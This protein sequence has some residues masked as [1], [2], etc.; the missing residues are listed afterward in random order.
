MKCPECGTKITT[1][2]YDPDFQWYECPKCEGCFTAD[3]IEEDN[4]GTSPAKRARQNRRLG[5][6]S[7]TGSRGVKSER[8]SS[9]HSGNRSG[10]NRPVA[11]GKKRRTEI[12]EDEEA[13]ARHEAEMLK[14]VASAE[15]ETKK[16]RD[17]VSTREVVNIMADEIQAYYEELGGKIDEINAQDKALTIWR[18]VKIDTGISARE[19]DVVYATCKEHSS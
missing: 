2:H 12:Q 15:P 4:N 17:E 13:A 3:E 19:I 16:H 8:A 1:K 5:S 6:G 18:Q 10:T 14:P 11:K 9:K 7:P